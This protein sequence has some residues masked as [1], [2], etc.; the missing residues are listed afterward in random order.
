MTIPASDFSPLLAAARTGYRESLG[1]VFQECR[2]YA[3]GIARQEIPA[4]LLAKGSASDLVQEAFLE[5][6]HGFEHFQGDSEVQ[7][8]AW[9]RILLRRR[10]AKLFRRFRTTRKR[11]I[12]LERPC[13]STSMSRAGACEPPAEAATPSA[14][15][16]QAE[17][18][19]VLRGVV[20]RLRDDYRQVIRLR[21]EE[22]RSFEEIGLLMQ[23]T[24]NAARLLWLRAIEH[25]KDELKVP[26]GR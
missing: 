16:S 9:L 24:A 15:V 1:R 4:D 18:V 19:Q 11:H 8:K 14:Q 20:D 12:G 22:E 17:Q 25:V 5:A 23:R 7:F 13:V 3:L 26:D 10:I 6:V 21:Y 2:Q